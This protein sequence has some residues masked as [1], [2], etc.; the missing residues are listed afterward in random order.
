MFVEPLSKREK[1]SS[2]NIPLAALP[3]IFFSITRQTRPLRSDVFVGVATAEQTAACMQRVGGPARCQTGEVVVG[4]NRGYRTKQQAE[5]CHAFLRLMG[6]FIT[7]SQMM[8]VSHE[9]QI[10]I[11]LLVILPVLHGAPYGLEP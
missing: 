3:V 10:I 9:V 6:P 4:P 11:S 7:V 8:H 2:E 5:R 1:R